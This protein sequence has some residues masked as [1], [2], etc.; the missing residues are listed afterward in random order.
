[1]KVY[2]IRD[3]ETGL[4]ANKGMYGGWSKNGHAW[5]TFGNV[6]GHLNMFEDCEKYLNAEVVEFEITYEESKK[7]DI[8]K[9][10]N[11]IK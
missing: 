10:M 3:K 5:S 1:L 9:N 11:V 4:Y 8:D 2:K 7:Y 6:N